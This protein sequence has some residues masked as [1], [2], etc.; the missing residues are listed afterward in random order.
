M[1]HA[2][3]EEILPDH[4]AKD[5]VVLCCGHVLFGDDG[6]GPAVAEKLNAGSDIPDWATVIDAGTA[7][8][9]LLFDMILSERRPRLV[10]VVDAVDLR[11]DAV[12]TVDPGRKP[13]EVFEIPLDEIPRVQISEFSL[14][15]APTSNLLQELQEVGGIRVA[16]IACQVESIPGEMSSDIS[17]AVRSAIDRAARLIADT[18]LREPVLAEPNST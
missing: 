6:F 18:Y 17:P 1:T 10:V 3:A 15:Q 12:D 11:A 13:G 8:R 2:W 4:C 5:V 14:H 9:E 7:V 16:V